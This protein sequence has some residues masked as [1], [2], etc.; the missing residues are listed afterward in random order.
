MTRGRAVAGKGEIKAPLYNKPLPFNYDDNTILA[1]AS[2][3]PNSS[4]TP[5]V[6]HI[7]KSFLIS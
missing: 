3:S 5:S 1:G 2:L 4:L 7:L 6:P